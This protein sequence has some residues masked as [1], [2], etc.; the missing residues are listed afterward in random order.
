MVIRAYDIF[1]LHHLRTSMLDT[2]L[3]SEMEGGNGD[4]YDMY[5][6]YDQIPEDIHIYSWRGF[7]GHAG[8]NPEEAVRRFER[9]TM[10]QGSFPFQG[11]GRLNEAFAA[12]PG[13]RVWGVWSTVWGIAGPIDQIL[14]G[15]FCRSMRS[16]DGGAVIPFMSQ[17]WN[18]DRP[19]VHT[20]DWALRIGHVQQR[21][22]EIALERELP[23]WRDGVKKEFFTVDVRGA[24]NSSHIDPV[25][26]DSH[27]WLDWGPNNDLRHMP[28][29]DVRFEEVPFHVIDPATNQGK[30]V[31][32]VAQQAKNP[33][34]LFPGRSP[35]IPVDRKA[36]SLVFLRTNLG[37][38]HLPGYRIT[39]EG[40]RYLTVPLDAMGNSSKG[41]SCYGIRY[42]PGKPSQ[43]GDQPDANFKS[44]K[45]QMSELFSL[46]FRPAWLGM[47]GCGDP[48]KVTLHEWVNPHP[49]LVIQSVSVRCPP[50]RTSGRIEVLFAITGIAPVQ[51][52]F[53]IWKDHVGL[54]LVPLNEVEIEPS[55]VP[56]IPENGEW[57]EEAGETPK[58]WLDAEGNE[59][60]QVTSFGGGEKGIQNRNLFKRR[61]NSRLGNGGVIQLAQAQVCK[62]IAL[63]G[64]FYWEY[65][66]RKVH[67]GLT[68][69]RRTDYIIE[70]SSDGAKWQQVAARKGICGEDG[71]HLHPLP[72]IPIKFVRFHLNA[73]AYFTPRTWGYS[74]GPGLTW[75]QLYR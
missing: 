30:S 16:V 28:R 7:P 52:D 19:S 9:V 74:S 6:A 32:M 47:T 33:R 40:G 29:G 10:L 41:Y 72:P 58:T 2:M 38:G 63:R 75:V 69:F 66:S 46:F 44:A 68:R 55:D 50:G 14:A 42:A 31:V 43:A 27:D 51:W 48:V 39:Y 54:P 59:V 22:G 62:K 4:Y 26:G 5:K 64:L 36:A 37:R 67:Y 60:C 35:E 23:S 13:K 49:D 21:I 34:L 53:T 12:P 56:V 45:H 73:K 20:L 57:A 70:V 71:A 24:C 61:D 17:A 11:R 25:P 3:L 8:S 65:H 18:P 15:Q 1:R